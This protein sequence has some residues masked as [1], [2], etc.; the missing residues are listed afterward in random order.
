M[1]LAHVDATIAA[2]ERPTDPEHKPRAVVAIDAGGGLGIQHAVRLPLRGNVMIPPELTEATREVRLVL[3]TRR[4]EP[5]RVFRAG[6]TLIVAPEEPFMHTIHLGHL[7]EGD[8]ITQGESVPETIQRLRNIIE[9]LERH[10]SDPRPRSG[11]DG[12]EW[13]HVAGAGGHSR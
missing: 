10:C 12:H 6:A 8:G 3:E 4:P 1:I 13:H 9:F 2:I 11:G 7:G 5:M